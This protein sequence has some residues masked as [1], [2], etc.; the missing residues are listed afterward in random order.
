M[1]PL[2]FRPRAFLLTLLVAIA[3]RASSAQAFDDC[4]IRMPLS[5]IV[6]DLSRGCPEEKKMGSKNDDCIAVDAKL[7]DGINK[8][9]IGKPGHYCLTEDLHARIEF[10]DHPAEWSMILIYSNNVV[11]DL[12]G[13]TLGRGRLFKN[14]GGVGIEIDPRFS[15]IQIKNGILQDFNVGMYHDSPYYPAVE[16]V[17]IYDGRTNTYHFQVSNIVLENIVFK[18]NSNNFEARVPREL[19]PR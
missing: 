19:G 18:N 2:A 12:R 6:P 9:S 1:H 16:E 4:S 7:A 14:P 11:L 15:N 13:H 10:A 5:K 17:P 8:L 3:T